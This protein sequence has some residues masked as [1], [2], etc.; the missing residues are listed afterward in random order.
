VQR[1]PSRTNPR[2]LKTPVR[3][4]ANRPQRRPGEP[5]CP[6][7]RQNHFCEQPSFS[8][9]P[10]GNRE[11]KRRSLIRSGRRRQQTRHD[12]LAKRL[13]RRDHDPRARS[14]PSRAV[15][16]S[17]A[18]C[19]FS[20]SATRTGQTEDV[21]REESAHCSSGRSHRQRDDRQNLPQ[22]HCSGKCTWTAQR[23]E[24]RNRPMPRAETK[25]D[26]TAAP[27]TATAE[28]SNC[29]NSSD[30]SSIS[31]SI[32]RAQTP[33]RDQPGID[34]RLSASKRHHRER[35]RESIA[36]PTRR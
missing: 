28:A 10:A 33:G 31:C 15:H 3:M 29:R 26:R 25:H 18:N 13:S 5:G 22:P 23:A 1:D 30:R 6:K 35:K 8:R 24:T 19:T 14:V 17:H 4:P 34:G 2:W 7:V 11:R 32:N 27:W 9:V 16:A 36:R 21:R 20:T 12:A